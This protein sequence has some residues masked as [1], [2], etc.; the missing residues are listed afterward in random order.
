MRYLKKKNVFIISVLLCMFWI[1]FP[2]QGK[3]LVDVNRETSITIEYR[4][5]HAE[6]SLYKVAEVTDRYEFKVTEQFASYGKR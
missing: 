6:F 4:I 5:P 2:V 1:T 3:S